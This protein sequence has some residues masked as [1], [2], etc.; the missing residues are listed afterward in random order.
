MKKIKLLFI[1]LVFL[2]LCLSACS[3]ENVSEDNVATEETKQAKTKKNSKSEDKSENEEKVA[4]E[5]GT[6]TEGKIENNGGYF[7]AK[8]N[9]VYFRNYAKDLDGETALFGEF[10]NIPKKMENAQICSYDI[11]TK[12]VVSEFD[13]FGFGELYLYKDT[14]Y[15][16]A[17]ED[18][19]DADYGNIYSIKTDGSERKDITKGHIL[20]MNPDNGVYAVENYKDG[21]WFIELWQQ[22]KQIYSFK[23][24]KDDN[25]A[26]F[27]PSGKTD[28]YALFLKNAYDDSENAELWALELVE[29]GELKKVGDFDIDKEE[30]MGA[31]PAVEQ[32]AYSKDK[33][34]FVLTL[35]GGTALTLQG[36]YLFEVDLN[37][38]GSLKLMDEGIRGDDEES[39]LEIW[40]DESGKLKKGKSKPFS[41]WSYETD[42]MFCDEDEQEKILCP[43]LFVED[44]EDNGTI[45]MLQ[46]AEFV[47]GAFFVISCDAKRSEEDDIGWREVYKCFGTD[48]FY[49]PAKER[50]QKEL[51]DAE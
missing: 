10:L 35:R 40:I 5:D 32:V 20:A 24:D 9:V 13:D 38:E 51:L 14:F 29:N 8:D 23:D 50:S 39:I 42:L 7:V 19:E 28:K 25:S 41:T 36:A 11:D 3:K 37:K 16:K 47:K 6:E 30:M 43:D 46:K 26:S 48:Y 27:I 4:N 1:A 44:I 34:Y 21:V 22:D 45:K 31:Y 33:V 15:L 12:E 17:I 2:L 49:I 18:K